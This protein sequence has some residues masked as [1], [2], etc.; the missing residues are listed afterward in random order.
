[1]RS[2]SQRGASAAGLQDPK[3]RAT[4]R[5]ESPASSTRT[6]HRILLG[7]VSR[8]VYED[9]AGET[10]KAVE[11]IEPGGWVE[12][13]PEPRATHVLSQCAA[14]VHLE[15]DGCGA[16]LCHLAHCC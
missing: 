11:A 9:D 3:T 2:P 12:A 4:L 5:S 16:T 13:H 6:I 8:P 1:S 14:A 15:D 10:H 7:A